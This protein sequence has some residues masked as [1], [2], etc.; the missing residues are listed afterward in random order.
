MGDGT[1]A[2]TDYGLNYGYNV[3]M[4]VILFMILYTY[5]KKKIDL[6]SFVISLLLVIICGSRGP[7]ICIAISMMLLFIYRWNRIQDSKIKLIIFL[8]F[9]TGILSIMVIGIPV[10]VSGIASILR[11]S[12]ISSRA[13]QMFLN[14]T[15]ADDSGRNRI[16]KIAY[17]MIA[18]GDINSFLGYGFYGDRYVIG[19]TWFYGYPHNIFLEL[20]IQY[21]ILFGGIIILMLVFNILRMAIRCEDSSWQLLFIT[22][23]GTSIKLCLSDSFWYYWPFWAL[24]AVIGSW[25]KEQKHRNRSVRFK[26]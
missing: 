8:L 1:L 3:V 22:L 24:L 14:G 5:N 9:M 13:L 21:G 10:F 16:Y 6:I 17:K 11:K 25:N 23:L 7:L 19:R 12:D 4:C 18:A 2:R 26:W 15:L 20:L